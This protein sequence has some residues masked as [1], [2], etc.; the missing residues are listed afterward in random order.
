[1]AQL[2][3]PHDHGQHIAQILQHSPTP[4][5]F[6]DI[7]LLLR[8]L[9]DGNRLRLFWILCHCEECVINLSAMMDMSSPAISHH[10]KQLRVS[11]LITSRR[12]GKE[13][14]YRASDNTRAQL[15]HQLVEKLV[16]LS[17]PSE[18][19]A[20]LLWQEE[21]VRAIHRQLTE[22]LDRRYTIQ[23]LSRQYLI[24]TSSLKATFKSVYGAPIAAYMKEYRIREAA[25]LLRET[26]NS[27]G[28]I[29]AQVGY[30]NQSKFTAAFQDIM[31]TLPTE[32]RRQ[33][34][35]ML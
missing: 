5:E 30:V 9:G 4:G 27:V 12:E 34:Q 13:V 29:A 28:E 23:E 1:M 11:R 21:V 32:Y 20:H 31:K 3:L 17:C 19:D 6:Q 14:Y 25:R 24:N 7:S 26:Q 8:Q 22:H 33:R 35:K 16:E 10:L 15:L 18:E 2:D